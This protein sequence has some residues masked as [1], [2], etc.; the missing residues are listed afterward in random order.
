MKDRAR[1]FYFVGLLAALFVVALP[2]NAGAYIYWGNSSGADHRIGRANLDGSEIN[3]GLISNDRAGQTPLA[4]DATHLFYAGPIFDMR[5]NLDGGEAIKLGASVIEEEEEFP[6][7]GIDGAPAAV[8]GE[9]FYWVSFETGFIGRAKL[10]GSSPEPEFLDISGSALSGGIAVYGG[11]IYWAA[12]DG[13]SGGTIGRASLATKVPVAENEFIKIPEETGAPGAPKGIAV[14][15]NGIYW[16]EI[17]EFDSSIP[18]TIGHAS[19]DGGA[20]TPSYFAGANVSY[21]GGIAVIG[22]FVYW[23]SFDEGGATIARGATTSIDNHFIHLPHTGPGWLAVNSA[24]SPPPPPP[25]PPPAG[26]N[27]PPPPVSIGPKPLKCRKGFKKQT[28]K[29]KARCVKAKRHHKPHHA[30]HQE[31]S[32]EKLR[33]S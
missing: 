33:S 18:A 9:H 2:A 23:D 24:T 29:G 27:P 26:G 21:A 22:G 14:D 6:A 12:F 28:V 13:G 31:N 15:E 8:D 5:A 16:T 10:D 20:A 7:E 30:H 4:V 25:P 3:E 19:L 11:Y 32:V 17:E 1:P